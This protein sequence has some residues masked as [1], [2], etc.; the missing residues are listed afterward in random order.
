MA[1]DG[2]TECTGTVTVT[3]NKQGLTD[4]K[5]I[6]TQCNIKMLSTTGQGVEIC[7]KIL[8]LTK[9]LMV[10]LFTLMLFK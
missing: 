10:N 7:F 9:D 1:V 5:I 8:F 6:P 4:K 2:K 3:R